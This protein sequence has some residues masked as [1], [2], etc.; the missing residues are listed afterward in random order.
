M[1]VA[2]FALAAG[3]C[4]GGQGSGGAANSQANTTKSGDAVITYFGAPKPQLTSSAGTVTVV[5]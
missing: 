2:G 3:G 4:G 1:W 5:G